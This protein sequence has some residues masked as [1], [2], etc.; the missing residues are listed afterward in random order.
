MRR[1]G[2]ERLPPTRPPPPNAAEPCDLS[3]PY[4]AYTTRRWP[5]RPRQQNFD[6]SE[7]SRALGRSIPRSSVRTLA[8]NRSFR[9]PAQTCSPMSTSAGNWPTGNDL[10]NSCRRSLV[11][12]L[13]EAETLLHQLGRDTG[14]HGTQIAGYSAAARSLVA[15]RDLVGLGNLVGPDRSESLAEALASLAQELERVSG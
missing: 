1:Q 3:Q 6:K 14:R 5:Y 2:P 10:R 8:A 7:V 11:D 13:Q 9:L 15:Q 4:I 12:E